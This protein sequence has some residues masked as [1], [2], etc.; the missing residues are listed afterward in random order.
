MSLHKMSFYKDL[1]TDG[2]PSII[3]KNGFESKKI[4]LEELDDRL[5]GRSS[6]GLNLSRP[7]SPSNRRILIELQDQ[8]KSLKDD[9]KK[10]DTLI[11]Q[12]SSSTDAE[13]V[14][15]S[16]D[17][18]KLESF[19]N[20]ALHSGASKT[21]VAALQV[22]V[23]HLTSQ[24]RDAENQIEAR[25]MRIKELKAEIESRRETDARL[26]TVVES[27][28]QKIQEAEFKSGTFENIKG[29]SELTIRTL[30]AENDQAR[31]RILELES[32][33][34]QHLEERE[35]AE[36][37]KSTIEK[38]YN[39]ILTQ[40]SSVFLSNSIKLDV[41]VNSADSVQTIVSLISNVIQENAMLKGKMLTLN[42]TLSNTELESKASR[43]TIM[44]LVS[45]VGREQKNVSQ[46]NTEIANIKLER[47]NAVAERRE[48][49]REVELL[50]E[51]LES[52]QKAWNAT[53]HELED[54]EQRLS[55]IDREKHETSFS[56]RSIEAQYNGF[57]ESLAH[58][59]S[60]AYHSV[61]PNEETIKDKI[62][63]LQVTA[64]DDKKRVEVLEDKMKRV[65]EHFESTYERGQS[66][67]NRSK[68][69]EADLVDVE[70]R[71]KHYESELASQEVI[72]D[73]LR[74]DKQKFLRFLEKIAESMKMERIS[75][76]IGFDMTGQALLARADQLVKLEADALAD[77]STHIY[78][79]Q[80]KLKTF[81][82]QLES[83]D[84][85]LDLLR[86]KITTL[87]ERIHSKGDLEI[88]RDSESG[89][90]RKLSRQLEKN[91]LLL[92]EA[93]AEI[94]DLKAQLLE[95]SNLKLTCLGQDK[96][97]QSLEKHLEKLERVRQKQ[98]KKIQELKKEVDLRGS[99]C[100]EQRTISDNAVHAL[101]SELKT[102]K[103]ALEEATTKE[104]QLLE[105]RKVIARMLGLDLNSL[106]VPD[107]EIIN[108]L[109]KLIQA[110]QSASLSGIAIESAFS[111]LEDGYQ[112][113]FNDAKM[114]LHSRPRG[115]SRSPKRV[116][117]QR[118]H[119]SS[120]PV[121]RD[122][123][124]Y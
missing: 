43:E 20:S 87:E 21:E 35:K 102:T 6:G 15:S 105:L 113:G 47:E 13:F 61:A 42:E 78:N 92:K 91:Q 22:K 99:T 32:R 41:S 60:D 48:L 115:R 28:Q 85:H 111:D 103:F 26:Q 118:R 11:T 37:L 58:L 73:G 89:K 14:K 50:K 16:L 38:R 112:A 80:R 110:H 59:L 72:K 45:E 54:R 5:L 71:L 46:Y 119:K 122:P 33:L 31:E 29:K 34:R 104:R 55:K 109:E 100:H 57:K 39:D 79:L 40:I 12:L 1:E 67:H 117:I 4:S 3:R 65:G 77:K 49:L 69:L 2:F 18:T 17:P 124:Q 123:R 81:K 90:V 8:V 95:G 97:M 114:I 25:E 121:R 62:K 107:Y 63:H 66:A 70:S 86:K 68:R 51:R 93:R 64:K 120:S 106:A 83:K 53:R 52:T 19:L 7:T 74:A 23:E 10:K 94:V 96:E 75:A 76:E 56:V 27:M 84:L 98:A 88:E 30:Q 44:R 101:T 116:T 36:Q 82:Q 9:L 108:R 24:L